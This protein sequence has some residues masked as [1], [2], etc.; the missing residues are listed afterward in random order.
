MES[1]TI[2]EHLLLFGKEGSVGGE[3]DLEA[4]FPRQFQKTL[5]LGMNEGL[6]HKVEVKIVRVR[7]DFGEKGGKFLLGQGLFLPTGAGAEGTAEVAEVGNFQIDFAEA[8]RAPPD[9]L[10][11]VSQFPED[12]KWSYIRGAS[13]FSTAVRSLVRREGL[14]SVSSVMS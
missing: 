6:A 4:C 3:D 11:I 10:I 12:F 2:Q 14:F 1:R 8:H 7:T 5:K 13:S 9:V